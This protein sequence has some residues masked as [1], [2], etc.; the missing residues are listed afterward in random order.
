MVSANLLTR[1]LLELKDRADVV[2]MGLPLSPSFGSEDLPA[3]GTAPHLVVLCAPQWDD[4]EAVME[5][6]VLD[7]VLMFRL[8]STALLKKEWP[9][10]NAEAFDERYYFLTAGSKS[11]L[12]N[13]K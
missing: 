3:K 8:G 6:S 1:R 4:F 12:S 5:T 13:D 9:R 11:L 7:I 2:I 10:N